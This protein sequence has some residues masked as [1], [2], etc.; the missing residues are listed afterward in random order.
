MH[1]INANGV[2][3]VLNFFGAM[4]GCRYGKGQRLTE[5]EKVHV[6]VHDHVVIKILVVVEMKGCDVDVNLD[7]TDGDRPPLCLRTLADVHLFMGRFWAR[8]CDGVICVL[9]R[10]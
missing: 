4:E 6:L 3:P 8:G 9:E 7:A 1:N 5:C 10:N 2:I